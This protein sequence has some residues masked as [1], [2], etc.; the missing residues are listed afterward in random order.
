M[1]EM[2]KRKKNP[3]LTVNIIIVILLGL[4]AVLVVLPFVWMVLSSFR[5]NKDIRLNISSMWPDPWTLTGYAAALT[6]APFVRWFINSV[7]VSTTVTLIVLFTSSITGFVFAK[8]KFPFK[9]LIFGVILAT[10]MV[11]SQVL[12]IP[13]FL[14]V[15]GLG[16]YN[17]LGALIV[18]MMVS[19]FGIFLC[20]QF[21]EDIPD[22]L[23]EAARIDGA[24]DFFIY[25]RIILPNIK[26][27]IGSL[28]IFSFLE[29]WNDYLNPLIMLNYTE[30]M[31][32][33]LA[34]NFFSSQHLADLSATMAVA[35]LVMVPVL[36]VFIMFQKQFIKGLALS[37]MK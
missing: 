2:K 21:I 18:P 17:R 37:G 35:S 15:K 36:I 13:N 25:A 5:T 34:L 1:A 32:L 6:R 29:S 11:P 20:K 9:N 28:T 10:M 30:K 26:P 22:S 8:Y 12:M 24:G 3:Y 14:I 19:M 33:P 7:F 23:C 27:C 4:L 31:T 16:L